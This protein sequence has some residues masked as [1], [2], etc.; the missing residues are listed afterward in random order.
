MQVVVEWLYMAA[1][2]LFSFY[3][4]AKFVLSWGRGA[5]GATITTRGAGGGGR[6]GWGSVEYGMECVWMCV[7]GVWPCVHQQS[8]PESLPPGIHVPSS[9]PP[10]SLSSNALFKIALLVGGRGGARGE[11]PGKRPV[12]LRGTPVFVEVKSSS[13]RSRRPITCRPST[14]T[15]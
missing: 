5:M 13:P 9:F 8:C 11:A 1:R 3:V 12:D 10:A 15:P 4:Y 14:W 6:A 2:V 7:F